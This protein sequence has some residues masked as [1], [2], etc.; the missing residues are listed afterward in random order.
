MPLKYSLT[1]KATFYWSYFVS[2]VFCV[3]FEVEKPKIRMFLYE[4]LYSSSKF[5]DRAALPPSP[6]DT[7][8]V[9]T[10]F[11]T[12][13]I[14]PRTVDMVNCSPAFERRDVDYLLK[15]IQRLG[16]Q[17]RKMLFL[18]IGADIGTFTVTVGNRFRD[19]DNLH[20]MAFEPA[21]SS[22]ALLKENVAINGLDKKV[23]VFNFAL[24]NEDNLQL[25]FC[26]NRKA[27]GSSGLKMPSGSGMNHEKVLART[28]DSA[29]EGVRSG[30]DVLIF[31][32]D[33]EGVERE[34][35][36]GAV[37]T[38]ASGKDI[39]LL[40]E[41]FVD[42]AITSYLEDI[43]ASFLSKLTPYNSWWQYKGDGNNLS[44]L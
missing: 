9:V 25:E 43:G 26:F 22:F 38:L 3:W 39:F 41:D 6:F 24:F 29:T 34:V 28:L 37:K 30:Y 14:R 21:S 32:M 31:K 36:K 44:K 11:G 40:V 17:G 42:P 23:D 16:R 33:V 8:T 20:L 19:Y 10:R 35:L 13:R 7:D 18:D 27:P 15:L 2:K 5:F 12:F 1:D 4:M